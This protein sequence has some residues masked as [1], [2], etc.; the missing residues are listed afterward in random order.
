METEKLSTLQRRL[1]LRARSMGARF[2]GVA[3]ITVAHEATAVQGGEY[4]DDLR[5]QVTGVR[6]CGMCVFV[7]PYGQRQNLA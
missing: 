1:E 3:D 6:T 2:F 4:R 7:C 5:D